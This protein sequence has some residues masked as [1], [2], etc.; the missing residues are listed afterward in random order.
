MLGREHPMGRALTLCALTVMIGSCSSGAGAGRDDAS[1]DGIGSADAAAV[2]TEE[3]CASSCAVT[4]QVTC[5]GEAT[6][7]EC[8]AGC[9]GSATICTSPAKAYLECFVVVGPTAFECNAGD[10]ILRS[11]FCALEESNLADCLQTQ[12]VRLPLTSPLALAGGRR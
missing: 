7:S 11:G 10:V 2:I 3:L 12:Q 4:S 5:P 6:M 9:L 1:M 8:V